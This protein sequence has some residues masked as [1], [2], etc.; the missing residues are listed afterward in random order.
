[1]DAL[2]VDVAQHRDDEAA[3]GIDGDA[4]IAIGLENKL[5]VVPNRG[6]C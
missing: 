1:M 6:C 4:D 2:F 3:V 5:L